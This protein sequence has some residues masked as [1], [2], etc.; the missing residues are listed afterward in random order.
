MFNITKRNDIGMGGRA[1]VV[2]W[3]GRS[4]F[5]AETCSRAGRAT[6]TPRWAAIYA[7]YHLRSFLGP[8]VGISYAIGR[9][10]DVL[11]L[12]AVHGVEWTG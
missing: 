7:A 8:R 9:C 11:L 12:E 4:E 6:W 10:R 1:V 2:G 3:L 5:E